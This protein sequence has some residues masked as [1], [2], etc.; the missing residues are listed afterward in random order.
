MSAKGDALVSNSSSH[1]KEKYDGVIES[2][3]SAAKYGVD[4]FK[5]TFTVAEGTDADTEIFTFQP[6]DTSWGGWDQNILKLSDAQY[7]ADTQQYVAYISGE[8]VRNSL[9]TSGTLESILALYRLSRQ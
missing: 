5:V 2:M 3:Q 6:F 9:S 1:V 8:T 7:D 4:Y